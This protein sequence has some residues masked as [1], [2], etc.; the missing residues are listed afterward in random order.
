MKQNTL[1]SIQALRGIAALLVVVLHS[2]VYL[3]ARN[4]I[5]KV[6]TLVDSGRAGVDI[7]FVISGFIMVLISGNSFGKPGAPQRFLIRRI[8]RIV[9][10]YWFYT[11]LMAI[12][13]FTLP[14]LFS[15]GK[16]FSPPT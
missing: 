2:Y 15:A 7:F 5:P 8:I 1:H 11:L 6:P 12:L 10:I 13:L 9:P 3:E 14:H 4:I 16:F